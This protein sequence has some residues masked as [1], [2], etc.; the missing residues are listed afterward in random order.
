MLFTPL[1]IR[2]IQLNNR[3]MVSPMCQYSG[4]DGLAGDWH[5]VHLGSRAVGGAALIMAEA[6]AVSPE[7][8]ISPGDLGLWNDKHIEPLKRITGFIK[9]LGSVAGIQLGHAGRKA[10]RSLPWNGETL[11]GKDD[12]GWTAVAP[13]PIAFSEGYPVPDELTAEDISR[14]VNAFRSAAARAMAAGFE[15]IEIHAAH[16]YL[17]NE[18]LSPFSNQRKDGYGGSFENRIRFLVEIVDA[19][20]CVWNEALPLFLRIS[21]T[22]WKDGGWSIDDSIALAKILRNKGVDLIDCSSGG[23]ITGV[24][25]PLVAGYQ[26]PLAEKIKKET[27]M[28][29]GAVGLISQ[30][31]QA[32]EII[33]SGKADL[34]IMAREFLRN[35]YF[36]LL[37]AAELGFDIP[38]QKQYARA[39]PKKG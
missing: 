10:G 26:V 27:G 16:G 24:K 15:I 29:T 31:K 37:A 21:A 17:I 30:A 25:I 19:V 39:K 13:S 36:P 9:S 11:L 22:E 5:L 1:K 34:V 18:F 28:L 23:N 20:R 33:S 3:I 2:S 35:P 38:W 12:G 8:R 32:E 14:I 4:E 6:T 7:G